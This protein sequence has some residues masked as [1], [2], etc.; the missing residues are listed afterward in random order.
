MDSVVD[1]TVA[2]TKAQYTISRSQLTVLATDSNS[3]AA[4][5][6]TVTSTGQVLGTMQ[7]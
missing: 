5:T 7:Q 2:I 3:S 6:V 4:L 1:D